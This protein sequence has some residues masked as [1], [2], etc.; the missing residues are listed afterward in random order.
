MKVIEYDC[1][2]CDRNSFGLMIC[3]D[4]CDRWF[5]FKCVHKRWDLNLRRSQLHYL[6]DYYCY[7]CRRANPSLKLKYYSSNNFTNSTPLNLNER[8]NT[9]SSDDSA[10][11]KMKNN[12]SGTDG[13]IITKTRRIRCD[14]DKTNNKRD[15]SSS[16][17]PS[18]T[19]SS[20]ETTSVSTGL[21]AT[22]VYP[23]SSSV[24][25]S[26]SSSSMSSSSSKYDEAIE[27]KRPK[28]DS[29]IH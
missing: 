5:H 24:D 14:N 8:D 15:L 23:F 12:S 6:T 25:T 26:S 11:L 4:R 20:S 19:T 9:N 2:Y 17:Y 21:A 3:C 22:I 16:I 1:L 10:A 27:N 13:G 29:D 7:P 18:T 28:E